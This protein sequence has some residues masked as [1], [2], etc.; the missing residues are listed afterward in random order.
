MEGKK[1]EQP[2]V[3]QPKCQT[4]TPAAVRLQSRERIQAKQFG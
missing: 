2:Q 1:H 3:S 4:P